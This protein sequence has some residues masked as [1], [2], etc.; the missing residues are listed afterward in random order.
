MSFDIYNNYLE[1][2]KQTNKTFL[3]VVC[4]LLWKPNTSDDTKVASVAIC[5]ANNEGG[6]RAGLFLLLGWGKS[7]VLQCITYVS[8]MI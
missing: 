5:N 3:R 4:F 7:C 8:L 1:K 6:E 2:K